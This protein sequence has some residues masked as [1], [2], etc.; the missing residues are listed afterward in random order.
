MGRFQAVNAVHAAIVTGSASVIDFGTYFPRRSTVLVRH[1][2]EAGLYTQTAVPQFVVN[3]QPQHGGKVETDDAISLEQDE[4]PAVQQNAFVAADSVVAAYV[5]TSDH[6]GERWQL[7]S[8]TEGDGGEVW[9]SGENGVGF[10]NAGDYSPK[11]NVDVR[12]EMQANASVYIR[13]PFAIDD[14]AAINAISRLTLRMLVDDG[15]V[16]YLNGTRVA[17]MAAPD[18]LAWNSLAT[19]AAEADLNDPIEIDITQFVEQLTVGDNVLAIHGLNAGTNSGDMLIHAELIAEATT[20]DQIWYTLDGSDPRL[21]GGQI[22]HAANGGTAVLYDGS[23]AFRG[24]SHIRA[25]ALSFSGE[26]SAINEATFVVGTPIQIAELNYNPSEPTS[27]E[28]AAMPGITNN[29]FEFVE[30]QNI[31]DDAVNI[32]GAQFTEGIELSFAPIQL[33]AGERA[34]VVADVEA[35]QLRYGQDIRVLGEYAGRLANGGEQIT[36]IDALGE[37]I[38]DFRYND[39]QLWPQAADG[40]GATLELA[41]AH[42]RQTN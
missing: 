28:L 24:T 29:D 8:F 2:L 33:D 11:I 18:V 38:F 37:V 19:S 27:D 3:D 15:F 41:E 4:G 16:A 20:A 12:A 21:A 23:L 34:V 1:L 40:V 31:S 26:W 5:P 22:N 14:P 32:A 42:R 25:R 30:L 6:L 7:P 39:N 35:F 10:D 13:M 9:T 36:L 17:A